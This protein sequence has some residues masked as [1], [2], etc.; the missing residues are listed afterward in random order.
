MNCR[1]TQ[2]YVGDKPLFAWQ[3]KNPLTG[4]AENAN[5]HS[6]VFCDPAGRR[7]SFYDPIANPSTGNYEICTFEVTMP[8]EWRVHIQTELVSGLKGST[9][10]DFAV[11]AVFP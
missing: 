10:L 11:K 5:G 8:G 2:I 7:I 9:V 4:L 6:I 3:V 1:N